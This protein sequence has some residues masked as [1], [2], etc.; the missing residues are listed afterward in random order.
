MGTAGLGNDF[1]GRRVLSK[2]AN[3]HRIGSVDVPRGD[4]ERGACRRAIALASTVLAVL[5]VSARL[6]VATATHRSVA[7]PAVPAVP[8]VPA[9]PAAGGADAD[10]GKRG[11]YLFETD[12]YKNFV[13]TPYR[14]IASP[15]KWN[16]DNWAVAG[17]IASGIGTLM[18]FD[19]SI[20]NLWQD[21]IR[22]GT[23]DDI[24]DI[25]DTVGE[26]YSLLPA[27]GIGFLAGAAIGDRN[28]QAASL[29]AV[30][31]LVITAGFVKALKYGTGRQRPNKSPESAFEFDGPGF[32]G[33]NKSFVSGHAAYAFSVASVF[34][35]AY[36]DSMFVAPVAYGLAGLGALSRVNDDK[37][38]LTDIVVG[39]AIG[40]VIGKLVH[41]TSPFRPDAN[42]RMSIR[43]YGRS[44]AT[45]V[46]ISLRF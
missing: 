19:E 1:S 16:L 28:L 18:I 9:V 26:F 40:I 27:S 13:L 23:T 12:Y 46:Q 14:I 41:R 10:Y 21:D 42:R 7:A 34:A 33:D 31:T 3:S 4:R 20:R 36:E 30:Q 44:G 5:A 17:L 35:S 11:G 43:P 45:G 37:H 38:W 25:G 15:F 2:I 39:G 22:N 29:E 32:D 6:S 24:A 8:V